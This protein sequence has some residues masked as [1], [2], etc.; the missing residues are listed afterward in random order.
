MWI[1]TYEYYLKDQ[2]YCFT[3]NTE[4]NHRTKR[5]LVQLWVSNAEYRHWIDTFPEKY[6]YWSLHREIYKFW[7]IQIRCKLK[8]VEVLPFQKSRKTSIMS[9]AVFEFKKWM[10]KINF[11]PFCVS[12]F[13]CFYV[14]N[15][16]VI[17][18]SINISEKALIWKVSIF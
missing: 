3:E 2:L 5:N 17:F 6:P 8:F 18:W 12:L 13:K 7:G 4:I 14:D 11:V 1:F 10:S 9:Q 16:F 15:I